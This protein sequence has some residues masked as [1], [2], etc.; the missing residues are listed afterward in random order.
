V[1]TAYQRDWIGD[2]AQLAGVSPSRLASRIKVPVL[3]AAGGQD[4]RAPIEQS[5]KM[6]KALRAAGVPVE[7]LYIRTEGHGFFV[8]E[9]RRQFY[10][11][12]LAFLDRNIG[13]A[14]DKTAAVPAAT[15][16]VAAP[17]HH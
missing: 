9:H 8:E 15:G 12:L 1:G 11:R 17:T 4:E 16:T 3:L 6:E 5:E 10:D 13:G 14:A 2:P 7:T